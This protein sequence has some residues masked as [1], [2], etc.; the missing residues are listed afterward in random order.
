MAPLISDMFAA[1]LENL[2]RRSEESDRRIAE[3]L[4]KLHQH[5]DEMKAIELD[6]A[7]D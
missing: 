2:K 6:T 3:H 4:K 5:L 7:T 1:E